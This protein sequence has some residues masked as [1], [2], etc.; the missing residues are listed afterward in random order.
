[1]NFTK[2]YILGTSK[3]ISP[4]FYIYWLAINVQK[5]IISFLCPGKG[6]EEPHDEF[7]LEERGFKPIV[8]FATLYHNNI[9]YYK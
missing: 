2:A 7:F 9:W 6:N 8:S 3:F 4:D 1:M 5:S